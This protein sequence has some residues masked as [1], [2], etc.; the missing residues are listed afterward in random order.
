[1]LCIVNSDKN[2]NGYNSIVNNTNNN[3]ADN[4]V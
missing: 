2:D 3:I 4:F 1:M